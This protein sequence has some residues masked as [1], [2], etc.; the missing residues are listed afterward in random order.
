[1]LLPNNILKPDSVLG[2]LV[3]DIDEDDCGTRSSCT[4][5][6]PLRRLNEDELLFMHANYV[7]DHP[8]QARDMV[9]AGLATL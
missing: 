1:M 7:F 9:R 8:A 6:V 4:E 2:R 3:T 5:I